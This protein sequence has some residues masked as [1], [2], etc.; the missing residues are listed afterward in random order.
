VRFRGD[1]GSGSVWVLS[2]LMVLT[3]VG[4]AGLF[5][6]GALARSA[7][8][9]GAADLAAIA[10]ADA[11]LH[12]HG[13]ACIVAARVAAAN[14]AELATCVVR[15]EVVDVTTRVRAASGIAPVPDSSAGARAGPVDLHRG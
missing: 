13:D 4:V 12:G 8:A 3:S 5:V 7:R 9:A 10:A 15:G 2:L 14:G 6:A 1:E 11:V